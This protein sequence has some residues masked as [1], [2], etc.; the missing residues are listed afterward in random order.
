M[1]TLALL[2]VRAGECAFLPRPKPLL[3]RRKIELPCGTRTLVFELERGRDFGHVG[4]KGGQPAPKPRIGHAL[5]ET[6]PKAASGHIDLD[7]QPSIAT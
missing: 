1:Q 7:G 3:G 2:R 6:G 4:G 5:L